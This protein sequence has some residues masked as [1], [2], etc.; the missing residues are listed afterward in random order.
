MHQIIEFDG[1][2]DSLLVLMYILEGSVSCY[3]YLTGI[4]HLFCVKITTNYLLLSLTG[5]YSGS[6]IALE[7]DPLCLH[8]C[9]PSRKVQQSR[10]Q[11]WAPRA[12]VV[13]WCQQVESQHHLYW[14]RAQ[15]LPGSIG[16]GGGIWEVMA[17][18]LLGVAL[19]EGTKLSSRFP[20]TYNPRE[21][22]AAPC[23]VLLFPGKT[24]EDACIGFLCFWNHICMYSGTFMIPQCRQTAGLQTSITNGSC[25][26][27][28]RSRVRKT[29]NCCEPCLPRVTSA[30]DLLNLLGKPL[31][32]FQH[33][34]SF[35][36]MLTVNTQ[37]YSGRKRG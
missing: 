34:S 4:E 15:S 26:W 16:P 19:R 27:T 22:K 2:S 30:W 9:R 20:I 23:L 29:A 12:V 36:C 37:I 5:S 35:R 7:K 8:Q 32:K 33:P 11:S 6:C 13:Q 10:C 31:V 1:E 24:P 17:E 14:L 28:E 18:S 3:E 21:R 25:N